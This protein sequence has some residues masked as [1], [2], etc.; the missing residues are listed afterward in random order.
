M[1]S[2][3]C[4]TTLGLTITH[5]ASDDQIGV[6]HDCAERDSKR[7]SQLTTLMDRTGGLGV[8]VTG[9]ASRDGETSDQVAQ[10]RS[11]AVVF[12]GIEALKGAFEP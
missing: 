11:I 10:T 3:S 5:H 1:P 9:E 6:I 4:W 7:I 2:R 12:A 8:D